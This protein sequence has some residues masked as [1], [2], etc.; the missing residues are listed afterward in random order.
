MKKCLKEKDWGCQRK[1]QSRVGEERSRL[2]SQ[3][4]RRG[5]PNGG[6]GAANAI[7]NALKI[8]APKSALIPRRKGGLAL[9][10]EWI[11]GAETPN[12]FDKSQSSQAPQWGGSRHVAG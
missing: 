11:E 9:A 5:E 12:R 4:R 7:Y 3:S 1:Q 2:S 6:R 10:T 8:D